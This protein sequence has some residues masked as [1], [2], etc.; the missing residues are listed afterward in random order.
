MNTT[1]GPK[2]VELIAA[3]SQRINEQKDELNQLDAALGDGDHG[4][5]ISAGFAAAS[6]Q[7]LALENP[8]PAE[9]L[10]ATAMA[11][12]NTMGGS[13]GALYGSFFLK[14]SVTV[15]DKT[16]LDAQSWAK[17]LQA[18][19]DGVIQRGKAELGGK[20]MVDALHPAVTA[21]ATSVQS[22]ASLDSS[23]QSAA[24]AAQQ[25]ADDT[26]KMVAQFGRAKFTGDRAIGHKDAG[27]TSV[28]LMFQTFAGT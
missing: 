14:A 12:M 13:S 27:A 8:T 17:L 24:Q 26:A 16:E 6:E 20:T 1:T 25:G 23:F 7:A 2:L 19:L 15:K 3:I 11:M 18:G 9:V 21:F 28:S 4:T 5:G 10:K 22:K